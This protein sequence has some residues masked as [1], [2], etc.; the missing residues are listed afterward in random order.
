MASVGEAE[1]DDVIADFTLTAVNECINPGEKAVTDQAL[2]PPPDAATYLQMRDHLS[3][4][5]II[6]TSFKCLF[7]NFV[8]LLSIRAIACQYGHFLQPGD[9]RGTVS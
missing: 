5:L 6:K 1:V 8:S 9:P 2:M 7:A 4:F 3:N